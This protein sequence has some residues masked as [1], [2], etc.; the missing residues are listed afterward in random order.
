MLVFTPNDGDDLGNKEKHRPFWRNPNVAKTHINIFFLSPFALNLEK[1]KL[2][3][4]AWIETPNQV[5]VIGCF[6]LDRTVD[7]HF[8]ARS[9]GERCKP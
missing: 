8:F 7:V 3:N 4:P 6:C 5:S 9:P 1:D 2:V